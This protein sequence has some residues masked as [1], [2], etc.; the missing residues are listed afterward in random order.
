MYLLLTT[1]YFASSELEYD[2]NGTMVPAEQ[3]GQ[4]FDILQYACCCRMT[5]LLLPSFV[6]ESSSG[7]TCGGCQQLELVLLVFYDVLYSTTY[8]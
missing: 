5:L 2:R 4:L 8:M 1:F 7:I 6:K 3:L